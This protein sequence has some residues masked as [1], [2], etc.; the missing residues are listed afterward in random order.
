MNEIE[1]RRCALLN[2][3]SDLFGDAPRSSAIKTTLEPIIDNLIDG[4]RI[5]NAREVSFALLSVPDGQP[6][7][8]QT[9]NRTFNKIMPSKE[10]E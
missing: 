5:E 10:G 4:V 3:I 6:I 9:V 2:A 8:Y 7:P 1:N